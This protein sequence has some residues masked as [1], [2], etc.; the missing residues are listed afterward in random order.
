MVTVSYRYQ[1]QDRRNLHGHHFVILH[2]T[3]YYLNEVADFSK[4][5]CLKSFQNPKISVAIIASAWFLRVYN[6]VINDCCKLKSTTL[7][8]KSSDKFCTKFSEG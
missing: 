1:T 8:L 4:V 5:Y 3:V 2:C 6:V 7:G